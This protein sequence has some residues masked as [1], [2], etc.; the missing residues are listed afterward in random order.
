MQPFKR[1]FYITHTSILMYA[2]MLLIILFDQGKIEFELQSFKSFY[3]VPSKC[4]KNHPTFAFSKLRR[5]T[6]PRLAIQKI[7]NIWPLF[8]VKQQVKYWSNIRPDL[9]SNICMNRTQVFVFS[10]IYHQIYYS[11]STRLR[12]LYSSHQF[13]QSSLQSLQFLNIDIQGLLGS[14]LFRR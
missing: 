8:G 3:T 13:L 1:W 12:S 10:T 5:I 2:P 11:A 9:K 7:L 6:Q 14:L 4:G